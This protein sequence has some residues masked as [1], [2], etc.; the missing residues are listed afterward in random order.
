MADEPG[1]ES[2]G[3]E[4][5]RAWIVGDEIHCSLQPELCDD[6]AAL[7]AVFASIVRSVAEKYGEAQGTDTAAVLAKVRAAFLEELE[8]EA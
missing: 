4:V 8:A 5:L 3:V 6:P 1:G 2:E 7:G